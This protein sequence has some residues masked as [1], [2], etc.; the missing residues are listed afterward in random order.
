[1]LIDVSSVIIMLTSV[2]IFIKKNVIKPSFLLYIFLI[3]WTLAL[4]SYFGI[5][6]GRPETLSTF[7]IACFLLNNVSYPKSFSNLINGLLVGLNAINSP[8]STFYLIIITTGLLFYRND[9]KVKPILQTAIGFILVLTCFAFFYP[10]HLTEL[11]QGMSKHSHNSIFGRVSAD[12]IG[13]F[14]GI[15]IL[16]IF[17][18]LTAFT[19]LISIVYTFYLLVEQKKSVV[20]VLFIILVAMSF[21]FSFK[22]IENAY[23]MFVLSPLFLF[24]VMVFF[25]DIY[26]QKILT[27]YL[28]LS[29][30]ALIFLLFVNTLGF[31]RTTLVF[32]CTQDKKVSFE[33][34]RK[35]FKTLSNRVKKN[36][37]IYVTF[38]LWPYCLDGYKQIARSPSDTSIQFMM[39]QQ[40]NSGHMQPAE[41]DGYK[42]IKNGFISD[43]P[44]LGKFQISNT[45]PWY[46]TAIYERE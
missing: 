4:F 25:V 24:M 45:Y 32:F 33:D 10:Y 2:Y 21:Y 6:E 18:P 14:Y 11:I 15:Y 20:I 34:F 39:V 40:S 41:I 28:N 16:S 43:H 1:M 23:N 9:F 12:R 42:L 8:V 27:N 30:I 7:F 38:S 31:I 17:H 3:F 26:N 5:S 36:K 19:F 44:K 22:I 13:Y 35:D 37:K 46:Q 29:S